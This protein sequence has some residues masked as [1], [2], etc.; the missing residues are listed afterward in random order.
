[1]KGHCATAVAL[2]DNAQ[3]DIDAQGEVFVGG[4]ISID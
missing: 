3:I 2:L 4:A 1:M